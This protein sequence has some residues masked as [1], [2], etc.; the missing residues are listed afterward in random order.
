MQLEVM[1]LPSGVK[2][3]SLVGRLDIEGTNKIEDK[4]A[5]AVTTDS[6]PVLVDL[7]QVEFIASIGVRLLLMNAKVAS[8]RGGKLVLYKPQPLVRE[9]LQTAG[10]DL[11]IPTYE[12]FD[13]ACSDLL[14]AASSSR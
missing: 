11:L 13:A 8:R 4:F 1:D 9:A 5:F 3:I 14:R 10:I 2:Q 7:S 6:M 12:D